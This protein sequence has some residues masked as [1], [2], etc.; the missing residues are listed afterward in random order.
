[1][2]PGKICNDEK[3]SRRFKSTLLCFNTKTFYKKNESITFFFYSRNQQKFKSINL[4]YRKLIH[5]DRDDKEITLVRN[6]AQFI[7]V[8]IL[9]F[10]KISFSTI[11]TEMFEQYRQVFHVDKKSKQSAFLKFFLKYL[12]STFQTFCF[13]RKIAKQHCAQWSHIS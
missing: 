1:M 12:I 5:N 10:F 7:I 3:Y 4:A 9:F 13:R 6:R 2:A 8:C 11:K